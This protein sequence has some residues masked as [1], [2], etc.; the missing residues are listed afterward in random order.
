MASQIGYHHI[1]MPNLDNTHSLRS[2][3]NGRL[4]RV[5][6]YQRGYSWEASNIRDFLDDLKYLSGDRVHYTGTVV[7]HNDSQTEDLMDEEG[8]PL[9]QTDVVD[10][11][12]R[13]TTAVILLDCL[14]RAL[15][16]RDNSGATLSAG[17]A[18]TFVKTR[19]EYGQS[20]YKLTL[21][22]G[23]N[24]FFRT[25]VLADEPGLQAPTISSE[26]RLKNAREQIESYVRDEVSNLDSGR[27]DRWLRE[28]LRKV[29]NRLRFSLYEV[30]SEAEVGIIFEVMNDRGKPLTELEKVKNYLLY[31]GASLGVGKSLAD[32]VNDAWSKILTRLMSANMERSQDED[33]LLRAHWVTRY[34]PR[35]GSWKRIDSVKDRFDVRRSGSAINQLIKDLSDYI[36][37]LEQSSIPFCEANKPS[38]PGAFASFDATPRQHAEV[39]EWSSKLARLG[40]PASMLPLLIA[41]RLR[42]PQDVGKYLETLR[43]CEAY[44]FRV[45]RLKQS[46]TH[47]GR[48]RL[49]RKAHELRTG[50][51]SFANAISSIKDELAWRCGD[52]E[53][54]RLFGQRV[55]DASWYGWRGLKYMLYEYEAH[56]ARRRMV[57]PK[58]TWEELDRIDLGQ[59]I[60]HILPQ[61]IENVPYWSS[62]FSKEDH[63]RYVHDIGNLTLS[64]Y[65]ESLS[66][67]PFPE[68]KGQPHESRR[69]TSSPFFQENDLV[70]YEDWTPE[71]IVERC[72]RIINWA[73]QRWSI[74]LSDASGDRDE[75]DEDDIDDLSEE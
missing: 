62:R 31:A 38:M 5:P 32:K 71:T 29:T 8:A 10:G 11:Q 1:T 21:N 13:L 66:N 46:H 25:N 65:N 48:A 56:L 15:K 53:F 23:T 18:K 73:K 64:R 4:F 7:I 12:Q 52:N 41:V 67:R 59:T 40:M 51:C 36:T 27:A 17:I 58:I 50:Q 2:L 16:G 42:H 45:W 37:D 9:T 39:V 24:T 49:Y 20:I 44:A 68:K 26:T 72:E 30:D 63:K 54:N 22:G 34:E 61:S 3:F 70:H 35:P 14:Q 28:L 43:L 6:D 33:R 19:D 75:V 57:N 47:A 55:E 74:D 60:E 69:F